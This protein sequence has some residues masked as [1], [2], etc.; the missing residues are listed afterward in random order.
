VV[1]TAMGRLGKL[2][3]VFGQFVM[4]HLQAAVFRRPG[5][6][7]TRPCHVL[8]VDEFPRYINPDFERLLA[9]GRSFRCAAVLALQTTSQLLLE[10]KP[11]F[12]DIVLENCR[13][14]IILNLG[15][16][17]DAKRF[18]AEFGERL[19]VKRTRNYNRNSLIFLPLHE[20]SIR[21]DEKYEQRFKYTDLMEMPA[22]HGVVKVV[23]DSRPQPP[24]LVKLELSEWDKN[25]R[26][27]QGKE[28]SQPA[29]ESP[30]IGT[31]PGLNQGTVE[32]KTEV[33]GEAST[34]V[35]AEARDESGKL[36]W[37]IN[38]VK[39]PG[40]ASKKK[41][42]PKASKEEPQEER[43]A[44]YEG[45]KVSQLTILDGKDSNDGFFV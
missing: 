23:V 33:A 18:A 39:K 37:E 8:Y 20:N 17:E 6:E 5:N 16:A 7:R 34:G 42:T 31:G 9:I 28:L 22:F 43:P 30:E 41:A 32:N 38:E 27:Y 1:N 40:R 45:S 11:A 44:E 24:Q 4:M 14:K 35:D 21:E 26:R 29:K 15:S 3:D 19:V 12:R 13:N 2:G 25:K 36:A 10:S